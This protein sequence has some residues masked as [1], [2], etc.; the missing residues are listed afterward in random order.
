MV[1]AH[2]VRHDAREH[3][4]VGGLRPD[5][6]TGEG[7]GEGVTHVVGQRLPDGLVPA[8]LEPVEEV[9]DHTV[10]QGPEGLRIDGVEGLG[11]GAGHGADAPTGRAAGPDPAAHRCQARR[12]RSVAI[13]KGRSEI[14]PSRSVSARGS[15]S[16]RSRR[17]V[18]TTSVASN[19]AT[20]RADAR[21]PWA[22]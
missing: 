6:L 21:P 13:W 19:P 7:A 3:L 5:A 1:V 17:S 9:V 16:G 15:W 8:A 22:S 11:H 10:G 2:R 20:S 4:G 14:E 18:S 12:S